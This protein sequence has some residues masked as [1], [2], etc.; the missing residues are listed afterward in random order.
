MK[1]KYFSLYLILAEYVCNYA[2]MMNKYFP[3]NSYR[4]MFRSE[5]TSSLCSIH[6]RYIYNLLQICIDYDSKVMNTVDATVLFP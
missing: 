2:H 6:S 3:S 5:I 1:L 4:K